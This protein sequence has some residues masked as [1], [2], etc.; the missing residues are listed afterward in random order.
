MDTRRWFRLATYLFGYQAPLYQAIPGFYGGGHEGFSETALCL[1]DGVATSYAEGNP[2]VMDVRL[3]YEPICSPPHRLNPLDLSNRNLSGARYEYRY[4]FD[5]VSFVRA[6]L[7][8]THLRYASLDGA[9][10]KEANLSQAD[11]RGTRLSQAN[12]THAN[13][14]GATLDGADLSGATLT[15]ANLEGIHWDESTQWAEVQGLAS[16]QHVPPALRQQLGL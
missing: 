14:T 7:S 2:G 4:N 10:L 1:G 12:L 13:L 6:N 8:H 3:Y 5:G 16:A 15:A 11:L 9:N